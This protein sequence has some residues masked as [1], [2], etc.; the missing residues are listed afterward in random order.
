MIAL[1][2]L[3]RAATSIISITADTSSATAAAAR[4]V[5]APR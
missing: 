3:S 1:M 4:M 2:V 5:P